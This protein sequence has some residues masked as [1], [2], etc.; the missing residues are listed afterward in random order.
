MFDE[1]YYL[2]MLAISSANLAANLENVSVNEKLLKMKS[3]DDT[4]I[5]LLAQILEELKNER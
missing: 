2:E 1:S 4:V 5:S 3:K